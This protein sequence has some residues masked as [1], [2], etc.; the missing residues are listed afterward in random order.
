MLNEEE[1]KYVVEHY[2]PKEYGYGSLAKDILGQ[3]SVEVTPSNVNNMKQEVKKV[4][5]NKPK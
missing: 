1:A 5:I 2:K 4:I 3:R